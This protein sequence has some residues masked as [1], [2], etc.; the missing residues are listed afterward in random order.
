VEGDDDTDVL[1]VIE[2]EGEGERVIV[3]EGL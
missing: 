3:S 1:G 2:D